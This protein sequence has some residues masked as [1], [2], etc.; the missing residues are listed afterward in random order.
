MVLLK[1][2]FGTTAALLVGG[3]AGVQLEKN[4]PDVSLWPSSW[5]DHYVNAA[6]PVQATRPQI[7][8][9]GYPG[10]QN[11]KFRSNYVLSYDRR[12]RNANW[13][14]E[15]LTKDNIKPN[16]KE[17]V[18]RNDYPFVEDQT[19]PVQFRAT[20]KDFRGTGFDRG[21]LAAAANH[22]AH[23]QWMADTMVLSNISPQNADLNQNAWNNLEKYTRSLVHHND[24]VYVCTGPLYLPRRYDDGRLYVNYLVLEPNHV[25]VPTHYFKILLCEKKGL[26]DIRS[27]IFPNE[28]VDHNKP[29]DEFMVPPDT[30]E[31]ASGLLMFDQLPKH[32]V[33]S[34]NKQKVNQ[35]YLK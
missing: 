25:A 17:T 23:G 30:I 31:R 13:V 20:N 28:S 12:L 2:V 3:A 9:Y 4:F 33:R 14:F 19:E 6:M 35:K 11:L 1:R 22:R 10:N 26:F 21:H 29:L 15:H 32:L 7:M 18:N 24:N 8:A 16:E 5:D 34:I 27:Y